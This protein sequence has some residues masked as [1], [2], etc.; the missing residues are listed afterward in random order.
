MFKF[1]LG[2]FFLSNCWLLIF[3]FLQGSAVKNRVLNFCLSSLAQQSRIRDFKFYFAGLKNPGFQFPVSNPNWVWK[4]NKTKKI[5]NLRLNSWFTLT[6]PL[7]VFWHKMV[8]I[9]SRYC[10][11]SL[12]TAQTKIHNKSF[13]PNSRKQA[14]Q[15]NRVL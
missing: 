10:Y 14:K 1:K 7:Y 6:G 12:E 15:M 13:S 2:N 8:F 4:A 9:R 11:F 3:V 5:S